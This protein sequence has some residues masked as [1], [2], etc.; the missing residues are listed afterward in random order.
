M[1]QQQPH[2]HLNR[3]TSWPA[4]RSIYHYD[5]NPKFPPLTTL[6]YIPLVLISCHI[7]LI[8]YILWNS[9]FDLTILTFH[10]FQP[11]LVNHSHHRTTVGILVAEHLRR[12]IVLHRHSVVVV[13]V[14][15]ANMRLV[16]LSLHYKL[17]VVVHVSRIVPV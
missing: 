16:L 4:G 8:I 11:P 5:L 10:I 17:V 1:N 13:P 6:T 3:L 15:L 12:R 9:D 2:Q 14:P 7:L